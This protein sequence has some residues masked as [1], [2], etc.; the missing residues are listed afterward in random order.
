MRL[1][2]HNLEQR[3]AAKLGDASIERLGPDS[4]GNDLDRRHHLLRLDH[5]RGLERRD[6]DRLIDQIEAIDGVAIDEAKPM[7][8]SRR[9]W[10]GR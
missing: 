2:G 7:P 5:R 9:N 8:I 10:R 3:R 4:K 1:E 6:R